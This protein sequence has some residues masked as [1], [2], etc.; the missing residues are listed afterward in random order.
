MKANLE[1]PVWDFHNEAKYASSSATCSDSAG[2][3]IYAT[4]KSKQAQLDTWK[5]LGDVFDLERLV[6]QDWTVGTG[7]PEALQKK[8]GVTVFCTPGK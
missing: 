2:V 1:C 6:G 4:E 3:A 5:M 7:D 8:M